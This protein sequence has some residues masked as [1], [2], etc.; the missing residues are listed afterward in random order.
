MCVDQS[1]I[2]FER[3]FRFLFLARIRLLSLSWIAVI[4]ASGVKQRKRKES[5]TK[6]KESLTKDE[7]QDIA[8]PKPGFFER[9]RI[10]E[11]KKKVKMIFDL[12]NEFVLVHGRT[13][14][15]RSMLRGGQKSCWS[16]FR[17]WG[18]MVD[19]VDRLRLCTALTE[20]IVHESVHSRKSET[21]IS[22]STTSFSTWLLCSS[23]PIRSHP[24]SLDRYPFSGSS[25]W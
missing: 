10:S 12:S 3:S 15:T 14:W 22:S 25:I 9:R 13:R 4:M 6:R 1:L 24:T 20:V 8:P 19:I 2:C 16:W 17:A 11:E 7:I 21:R 18:G 23:S 5:L